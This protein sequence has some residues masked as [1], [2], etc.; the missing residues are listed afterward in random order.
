M[1]TD[2]TSSARRERTRT[3]L[4]NELQRRSA[5][6]R[7]ELSAATGLSRSAI[8]AAV[9]D[10]LA[11]GLVV[12]DEEQLP[13]SRG[14]R[15]SARLSLALPFGHVVGIDFGHM[16]VRV[17]L[18]DTAGQVVAEQARTV[19]TDNQAAAALDAAAE[20]VAG[21]LEGAHLTPADLAAVAAAIPGPINRRGLISSPTIL[22]SW[23]DLN[24][25]DELTQRIGAPV[26]IDNDANMGAI[27]EQRFGAARDCTDFLYIQASHG[28]GAGIII[29][30][31]PYRGAR[32]FAGEIGH[33]Q[34]PGYNNRCRCGNRGCL[35]S[36]ISVPEVRRQL[37]NTHLRTADDGSEPALATVAVDPVGARILADA[38][39][40]VGRVVADGCNWF[41]PQAV[42]LGG[43]LGSSGEA[44]AEGFR[45]SLHHHA[46]PATA[47]AVSVRSA[48]LG[49]RSEVMG[50]VAIA[51]NNIAAG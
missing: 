1:A 8:A 26:A 34:L 22:S 32:G 40:M 5:S 23:I 7:A 29:R 19:D 12:E 17:A 13:A 31:R 33:T 24:P 38:G 49:V 44:F 35:E 41:N 27:G 45:Q 39:R 51:L 15:R 37:A 20:L 42:I 28:I 30:G 14:G 6:T 18:A 25:A 9:T 2:S 50:A 11:A 16:H 48:G 21:L 46:Q 10:L 43:E 3:T 47:A 36:V 4:L